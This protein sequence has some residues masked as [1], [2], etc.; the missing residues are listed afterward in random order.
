MSASHQPGE[1]FRTFLDAIAR[2]DAAKMRELADPE[3]VMRTPFSPEGLPTI[4]QGLDN[5]IVQTK[6]V[7]EPIE[8]FRWHDIEVYPAQEQDLF[9][10]T[11]KSEVLL[12]SGKI[13]KN[14][15]CFVVR[16]KNGKIIDHTE[17]FNPLRI[18]AAFELAGTN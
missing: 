18:I 3:L 13:Y 5:F 10:A 12:K 15:Y 8:T 9:F 17:Y 1:L 16:T 4:C 7:F 14:D 6:A 11:A 2:V